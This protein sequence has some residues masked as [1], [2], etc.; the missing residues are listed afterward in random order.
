[1]VADGRRMFINVG[2][3]M[4][5]DRP[6]EVI[7]VIAHEAGHIAGG[8]LARTREQLAKTQTAAIIAMLLGAAAVAAAAAAGSGGVAGQAGGAAAL[9]GRQIAE[10]SFLAYRRSEERNAD[11]AAVNYLNATG[12]SG[13]GMLDV[14][15]QFSDQSVFTS[16][17]TDP[18][19]VSHPMPR[20]R[21][22]TLENVVKSSPYYATADD[23]AL[24]ARHNLVKAKLYG[25][26]ESPQAVFRRYPPSD[27]SLPA[28]YAR[29][30]ARFRTADIRAA[31]KDIDGLIKSQPR[32][33][34][35]QELKGQALM[36]SGRPRDA[37]APLQLAVK[38]AP[39]AG[40]IRILLGQAQ[41]ASNDNRML[42]AAIANL[43][44]GLKSEP[45]AANGFRQLAIAYGRRNQTAEASLASARAYAIEGQ[46]DLARQQAARAKKLFKHGSPGW[47][48]A[49]DILSIRT[50]KR[51]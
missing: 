21:I 3:L 39:D 17:F 41:V 6:N 18:Y 42:D 50:N 13:K 51:S 5:T 49:D 14:F 8:H 26:L 12:Q 32:N 28:R 19:V 35:F 43:R 9:G 46:M 1:F 44:N 11:L 33:P 15:Q 10:R 30:I 22:A 47:L 40:L 34:Y 38:L 2:T 7:G 27:D 20:D 4:K 24:Q 45:E 16:R 31:I 29:A 37:I 25:F 36:E 23:P 48:Q